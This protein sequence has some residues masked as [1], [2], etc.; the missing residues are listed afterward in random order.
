MTPRRP[1]LLG[2]EARFL[3]AR[4]RRATKVALPSPYLLGQRMWDPARSREAYPTREAFMWALVPVLRGELVAV[5]AAGVTVAQFDD[6]HLCLF[7]DPRVRA[8]LRRIPTRRRRCAWICSTRSW[9]AWTG[10]GTAVHLCRRNK[11]RGRAGSGEGG[12]EPIVPALRRL[13]VRPVRARVRHSG[14]RATSPCC[15]S[16]PTTG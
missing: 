11:G 12:Y 4:A 14:G 8:E 5:R 3:V 9:R 15:A 7:V 13:R 6:P 10:S 16:C 2:E 1:G